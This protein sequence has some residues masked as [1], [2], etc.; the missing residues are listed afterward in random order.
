MPEVL[1]LP[2]VNLPTKFEACN[3]IVDDMAYIFYGSWGKNF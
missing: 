3:F 1:A 2:Y